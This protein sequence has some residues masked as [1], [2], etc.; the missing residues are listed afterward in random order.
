VN[1]WVTIRESIAILIIAATHVFSP[2]IEQ[3]AGRHLRTLLSVAGGVAVGYVFVVLLPK[4]GLFT[5]KMM[6][7]EAGSPEILQYRLY[8]FALAGLL[9]YFA[10][11]QYRLRSTASRAALVLHALVFGAY[12]ALMGYLIAHVETQRVGY[13]PHVLLGLI[14]ALHL[15]AV[16][17]QL[18]AWHGVV[19]DRV[20]RWFLAGAVL[21]GWLGGHWL[22]VSETALAAWSSILAGGILI[23]VFS[24]EL[25]RGSDAR[26]SAF[27]SGVGII[28]AAAVVFRTLSRGLG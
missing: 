23:N 2:R 14:L 10:A 24:E 26:V 1:E 27:L 28:V 11:D 22:P 25:P 20:L 9:V 5:G 21:A 3:A 15:F 17:H 7:A 19:F 16:D 6:A 8:L 4:M 18:R 12:S 13:V